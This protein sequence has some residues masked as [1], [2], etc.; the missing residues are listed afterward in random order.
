VEGL[1][2]VPGRARGVIE[3]QTAAPGGQQ[4]LEMG[5]CDPNSRPFALCP[6]IGLM[7]P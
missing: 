3:R 5:V 6:L 2:E 1:S 4:A 7:V